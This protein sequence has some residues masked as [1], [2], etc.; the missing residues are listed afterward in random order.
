MRKWGRDSGVERQETAPIMGQT[1]IV[2]L[3]M[4][5]LK[6]DNIPCE[7]VLPKRHPR[8]LVM[9]TQPTSPKGGTVY[10]TNGLFKE[11]QWHGRLKTKQN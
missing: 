6:Q 4:G 1:D 9:K 7:I 2:C 8:N 5:R 3:L 11:P 10:H